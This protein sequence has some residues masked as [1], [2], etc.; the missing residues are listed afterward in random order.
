MALS[1]TPPD[2]FAAFPYS[3]PYPIQ[4]DLMRHLYSAIE[5]KK[6]SIV[7]SPTGTGKTLSLLCASLTWLGDEKDRARK[8][9]MY[10]LSTD[11]EP[12]WVMVQTVERYRR[13]LEA[14]DAE[15]EARLTAARNKE[16]AMK[17]MAKARVH[18]KPK[19]FNDKTETDDPGDDTFLP[20]DALENDDASDNISPALRALMAKY[21]Y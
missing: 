14:N 8:G 1:L 5:H 7:E 11:N 21:E 18:K 20:D 19:L 4:V 10:A 9:K 2:V 16:A 17:K 15:Y 3:S 6:V 13:E 12:D